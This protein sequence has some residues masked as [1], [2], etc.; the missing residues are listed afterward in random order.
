MCFWGNQDAD[1][2]NVVEKVLQ[3]TSQS[4]TSLL[5]GGESVSCMWKHP[6]PGCCTGA[7][8]DLAKK[9]DWTSKRGGA[10][11]EFKGKN[12][13][14][15]TQYTIESHRSDYCFQIVPSEGQKSDFSFQI[16]YSVY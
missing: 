16:V 9:G 1:Q 3:A 2:G 15:Y 6:S 11:V 12:P 13:L 14:T 5:V 8:A 7:F 4:L 10:K